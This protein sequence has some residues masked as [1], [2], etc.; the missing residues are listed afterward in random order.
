MNTLVKCQPKHL[1][2]GDVMV[3]KN[4][5]WT[6]IN[7]EGPDRI[8]TFEVSLK[9]AYGNQRYDLVTEPVTILM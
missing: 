4:H 8:G 3:I 9:D 2:L 6:V 5:T 7:V 1:Q